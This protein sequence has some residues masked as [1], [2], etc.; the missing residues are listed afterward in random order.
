VARDTERQRT[1]DAESFVFTGTSFEEP[2]GLYPLNQIARAVCTTTWW[3]AHT[4]RRVFLMLRN[5]RPDAK[6][7]SASVPRWEIRFAPRS[8]TVATLVH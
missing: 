5:A 8:D 4:Y 7:S 6:S 1:Y 2:V 3:K